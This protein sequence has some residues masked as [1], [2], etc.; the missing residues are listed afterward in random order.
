M[1]CVGKDIVINRGILCRTIIDNDAYYRE[2][3][4]G[5]QSCRYD[6]VHFDNPSIHVGWWFCDTR[7]PVWCLFGEYMC[8]NFFST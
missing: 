2:R 5:E 8:M 7:L 4:S 1:Y 3:K 6:L